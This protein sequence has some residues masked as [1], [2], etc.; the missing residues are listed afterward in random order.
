MGYVCLFETETHWPNE[1]LVF[2]RFTSEVV[3]YETYFIYSTF[4]TFAFTFPWTNY[5][6]HLCF[7]HWLYFLKRNIPFASFFFSLLF[8]HISQNFRILLLLSIH[9]I[10]RNCP[11]L[12]RLC[13]SFCIFLF[14]F[15][16]CFF[17]LNFLFESFFIEYFCLDS[18]QGLCL[19]RYNFSLPGL[20][21]TTFL[22]CVK[23]LT[24]SFLP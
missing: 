2:W 9:Q 1:T 4:P 11:I 17:H 12:Y 24:E 18:A 15:F 13:F 22:L 3:T 6:E 5:F 23:S 10:C 16:D 21:L 19:F 8:N 20:F 14:V 7:C